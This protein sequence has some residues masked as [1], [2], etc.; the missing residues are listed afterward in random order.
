MVT[1]QNEWSEQPMECKYNQD[2]FCTH[3]D[4]PMCADY[5]PVPD[6]DGVCQY[7]EREDVKYKLTPQ[8]CFAVALLANNIHL[9]DNTIDVVWAKF[10]KA[11]KLNGYVEEE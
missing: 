4:C 6:V 9:D 7:E 1:I 10:E 5:C 2:E 11:M 3:L 8:S